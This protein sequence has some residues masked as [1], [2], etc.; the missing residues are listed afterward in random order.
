MSLSK[1]IFLKFLEIFHL[2]LLEWEIFYPPL[3]RLDRTLEAAF[4]SLNNPGVRVIG[5]HELIRE[6]RRDKAC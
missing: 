2:C 3:F 6:G 4:E 5:S 1:N